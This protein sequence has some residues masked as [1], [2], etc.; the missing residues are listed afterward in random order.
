[1]HAQRANNDTSHFSLSTVKKKTKKNVFIYDLIVALKSDSLSF[2]SVSRTSLETD[3][4]Q[5]LQEFGSEWDC[6]SY[7]YIMVRMDINGE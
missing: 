2:N 1:M 7:R 5:M 4:W 3:S 6:T